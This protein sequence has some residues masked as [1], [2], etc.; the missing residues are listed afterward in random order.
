MPR[1]TAL[2]PA[3]PGHVLVELDGV[4]WRTIPLDAATRVGLALDV[5][6]DRGRARALRRELRRSEALAAAAR[7]LS[8][9]GRSEQGLRLLLDR[10]GV[11]DEAREDAVATL[12]RAGALDDD[13]YAV[14]RA[15]ALAERGF[16]DAAIGFELEREGLTPEQGRAALVD[17]EPE[18]DRAVRLAARRGA[19]ART[20][21][22]LARRGFG[23][24]AIE[25]AV[26]AVAGDTGAELG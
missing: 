21:R 17:L 13:R 23:A 12:R 4:R 5:E 19:D 24:D 16:G 10:R 18:T 7:A 22:W 11:G 26:P 25:A 6:L 3:R 20:A 2:R 14:R 15:E 1:V 8:R 9:R